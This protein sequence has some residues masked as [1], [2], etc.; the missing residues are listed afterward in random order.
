MIDGKLTGNV[1]NAVVKIFDAADPTMTVVDSAVVKEGKFQL[2]GKVDEPTMFQLTID[3][4]D[5]SLSEQERTL[6]YA[7]YVENAPMTFTADA[8]TMP[9]LFY[10]PDRKTV[11]PVITGSPTQELNEKFNAQMADKENRL[12]ELSEKQASVY[13]ST[14]ERTDSIIAEAV[15]MESEIEAL[16]KECND[17]RLDF[18]RKNAASIVALDQAGILVYADEL[19][20]TDVDE[21][22]KV[23]EPSWK[24]KARYDLLVQQMTTKKN[25]ALGSVIPDADFS[26]TDGKTVKLHDVLPKE[27]YALV[28]FWASWCS[29]CRAEIPHLKQIVS[30]YPAFHIISLS[31]DDDD[32]A[33]KKALDQDKP[34]TLTQRLAVREQHLARLKQLQ[35][36]DR[37]LTAG[38]NPAIDDENPGEA[39]FTGSTVIAQFESLQ[40]AKDWAA[41][42]PYVEAGVYGDVIIKPFKKVF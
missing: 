16:R 11:N 27:G 30:K 39:G 8:A 12:S 9:T 24:G 19:T 42:D 26:T 10:I 33:W 29:P 20:T 37:L 32:A 14:E 21:I 13:Y 4:P 3:L 23:L 28:E 40:A 36:E 18:I 6:A 2:K 41:Q 34:N 38:P 1:E 35:A 7:F 31:V 15:R 5:A 22:L 17:A 25:M